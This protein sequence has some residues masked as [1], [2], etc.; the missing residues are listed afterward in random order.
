MSASVK[1]REKGRS[2][3]GFLIRG[4]ELSVKLPCSD[5]GERVQKCSRNLVSR[6][7][8]TRPCSFLKNDRFYPIIKVNVKNLELSRISVVPGCFK[9]TFA[10]DMF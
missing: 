4:L 8:Y 10:P 7:F 6:L 5:A 9:K 2:D 3:C 1:S